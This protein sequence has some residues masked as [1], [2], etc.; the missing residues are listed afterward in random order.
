[1]YRYGSNN[2]VNFVVNN[3]FS[4]MTTRSKKSSGGFNFM[5]NQPN[6]DT[7]IKTNP[8]L[9]N[10]VVVFENLSITWSPL[11]K[12][13][14]RTPWRT[15]N[16]CTRNRSIIVWIDIIYLSL[17]GPFYAFDRPSACVSLAKR[18][19]PSIVTTGPSGSGG[20]FDKRTT[21]KGSVTARRVVRHPQF[22]PTVPRIWFG[23][24]LKPFC[25]NPIN[26]QLST[27]H[28]NIP[29]LPSF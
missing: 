24:W 14:S 25:K 13:I 5:G 16:R 2:T 20:V 27:S 4:M 19:G 28:R 29:N 15:Y 3:A 21:I 22:R 9:T 18:T 17:S 6:I 12:R 23:V 1:M 7:P 8:P 10:N 26:S 11:V